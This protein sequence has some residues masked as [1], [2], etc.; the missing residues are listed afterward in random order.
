MNE[1]KT[2]PGTETTGTAMEG[3]KVLQ[4]GPYEMDASL[5]VQLA[6]VETD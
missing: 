3:I 6:S 1:E 4:D 2:T 5:P